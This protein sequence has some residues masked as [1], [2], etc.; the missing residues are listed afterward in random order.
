MT[1][2]DR[3]PTDQATTAFPIPR[4]MSACVVAGTFLII[5]IFGYTFLLGRIETV[6]T[7][8]DA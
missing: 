4:W 6:P 2:K 5:G 3:N 1:P 7:P 8:D